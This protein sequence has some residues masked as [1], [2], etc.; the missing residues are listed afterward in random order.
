MLQECDSLMIFVLSV[1]AI[2]ALDVSVITIAGVFEDTA[3]ASFFALS[4]LTYSRWSISHVVG[5]SSLLTFTAIIS[6]INAK[7]SR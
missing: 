5:F 3:E 1:S 7:I 4:C 2:N 6:L